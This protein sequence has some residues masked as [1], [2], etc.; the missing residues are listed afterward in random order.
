MCNS[1]ISREKKNKKQKNWEKKKEE[2]LL[3]RIIRCMATG[4]SHVLFDMVSQVR[5]HRLDAYIKLH[6]LRKFSLCISFFISLKWDIEAARELYGTKKKQRIR[7]ICIIDFVN[8]LILIVILCNHLKRNFSLLR[9]FFWLCFLVYSSHFFFL[10]QCLST[11]SRFDSS[12]VTDHLCQ[13][14]VKSLNKDL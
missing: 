10:I 11:I 1:S 14:N 5:T 9:F 3:H 13:V 4:P 7:L 12:S 6:V 2:K 8:P